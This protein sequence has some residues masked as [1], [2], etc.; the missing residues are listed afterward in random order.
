MFVTGVVM[1]WNRVMKRRGSGEP[2]EESQ[3]KG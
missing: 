1:W 2:V 3:A